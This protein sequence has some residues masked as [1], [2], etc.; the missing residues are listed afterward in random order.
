MIKKLSLWPLLCVASIAAVICGSG[1]AA[2]RKEAPGKNSHDEAYQRNI[3]IFNALTRE[4]EESYVDSIPT[5]NIT[6]TMTRRHSPASP[7]ALMAA[8]DRLYMGSMAIR[9]SQSRLSARRP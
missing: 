6:P 3:A 7:R 5:R 2:E 8:S 1:A 9:I 4:L